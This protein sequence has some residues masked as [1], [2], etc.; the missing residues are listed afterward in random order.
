[1]SG[2]ILR[3]GRKLEGVI[4]SGPNGSN[5][6]FGN[7]SIE[8]ITVEMVAGQCA[9][10]P[11]ALVRYKEAGHADEM[12]NLAFAEEVFLAEEA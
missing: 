1:M 10:L 12:L 5:F 2:T 6:G 3:E 11:W 9:Y 7:P 4:M 8:S